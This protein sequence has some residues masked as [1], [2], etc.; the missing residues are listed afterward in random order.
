MM[1]SGKLTVTYGDGRPERVG[2]SGEVGV[3]PKGVTW[4]LKG[5]DGGLGVV[6]WDDVTRWSTHDLLEPRKLRA[7][8]RWMQVTIAAADDLVISLRTDPDSA[9]ALTR[10]ARKTLPAEAR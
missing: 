2:D 8:K 7:P 5:A 1:A 10:Q 6:R 9:A 4:S 3:G